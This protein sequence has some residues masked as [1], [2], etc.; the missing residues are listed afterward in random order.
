MP[1]GQIFDNFLGYLAK[2]FGK[3]ELW[4]DCWYNKLPFNRN[5]PYNQYTILARTQKQHFTYIYKET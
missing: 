5:H 3:F 4:L 2:W 1:F